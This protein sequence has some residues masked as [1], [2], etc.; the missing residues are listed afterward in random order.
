[1]NPLAGILAILFMFGS[2]V[3][4]DEKQKDEA[5]TEIPVKRLL[6]HVKTSLSEDDAQ[7]CVAP[8]V[9]LAALQ[10]GYMVTLLFDGSAVTSVKK[11]SWLGGDRTPMDKAELPE[12]ERVSLS[13]QFGVPLELIP[14]DYGEYL[15]FLKTRG[16]ELVIN[17]TMMLLYEIEA[18]EIDPNL[19]PIPLSAMVEKI[20]NADVYVV[21]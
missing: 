14:H 1:M 3:G 7:I 10:K 6:I 12:R 9:A 11:G 18:A 2:S 20:S 8:N 5:R 16:A 19:E 13:E 4:A 15:G 17:Q 21:Y